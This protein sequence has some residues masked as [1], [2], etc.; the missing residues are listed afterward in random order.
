MK[1][2]ILR[3]SRVEFRNLIWNNFNLYYWKFSLYIVFQIVL[4]SESGFFYVVYLDVWRKYAQ[5]F[6]KCYFEPRDKN[7]LFQNCN[8]FFDSRNFWCYEKFERFGIKKNWTV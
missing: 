3:F 5:E 6:G 4:L 1:K 8:I 7:K 2:L